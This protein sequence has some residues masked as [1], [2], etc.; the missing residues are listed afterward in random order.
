MPR[1]EKTIKADGG[2]KARREAVRLSREIRGYVQPL[3]DWYQFRSIR[4]LADYLVKEFSSETVR[5]GRSNVL[6]LML[7]EDRVTPTPQVLKV[8]DAMQWLFRKAIEGAEKQAQGYLQHKVPSEYV[9]PSREPLDIFIN[10]TLEGILGEATYGDRKIVIDGLRKFTRVK[11][12]H[13]LVQTIIKDYG[14]TSK[15]RFSDYLSDHAG[16]QK[17]ER[18]D[19]RDSGARKPLNIHRKAYVTAFILDRF[20]G[21]VNVNPRYLAVRLP[22][23]DAMLKRFEEKGIK[24]LVVCQSKLGFNHLFGHVHHNFFI[25]SSLFWKKISL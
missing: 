7:G 4:G 1:L 5:L 13:E 14:F 17:N 25:I 12:L 22:E 21:R 18:F 15:D 20:R 24:D 10:R 11:Q 9:L 19:D 8:H 6:D 2:T 3:M 16:L 23:Y